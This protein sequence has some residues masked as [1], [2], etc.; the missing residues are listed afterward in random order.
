MTS[1]PP[2]HSRYI[3]DTTLRA[4]LARFGIA[5]TVAI[6]PMEAS[7][8]NDNFIVQDTDR[9]Y[10]LRR[11]RRN[12]DEARVRFQLRFQQHLLNSGFPTSRIIATPSGDP[13]VCEESG[14]WS[15]FSYVEGTEF[16]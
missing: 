10:V 3:P 2:G 13:M 11:Y 5:N 14:L 7:K 12:N 9:K 6:E 8:R 16:D 4:V 15:L 1:S